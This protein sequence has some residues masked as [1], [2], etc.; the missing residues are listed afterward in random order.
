MHNNKCTKIHPYI[1]IIHTIICN[2]LL[3][4]CIF[5]VLFI[6]KIFFAQISISCPFSLSFSCSLSSKALTPHILSQTRNNG[7]STKLLYTTDAIGLKEGK[8]YDA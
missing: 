8:T 2:N 6:F 4:L 5:Y 7:V 3:A 1:H